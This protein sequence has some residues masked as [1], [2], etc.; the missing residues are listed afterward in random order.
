MAVCFEEVSRLI[1]N[2]FSK[3]SFVPLSPHTLKNIPEKYHPPISIRSHNT[4][5]YVTNAL[6]DKQPFSSVCLLHIYLNHISHHN[7]Q[8]PFTLCICSA[9]QYCSP[10]RILKS[11]CFSVIFY[12]Y[13]GDP[14]SPLIIPLTL[15][16]VKMIPTTM[17]WMTFYANDYEFPLC[18]F[19]ISGTK[20]HKREKKKARTNGDTSDG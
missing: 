3:A 13:C 20:P 2:L 14:M 15:N 1:G 16:Y 7:K 11:T 4:A 9:Q 5:A 8:Y 10:S 19:G 18:C 6:A 12:F 17:V